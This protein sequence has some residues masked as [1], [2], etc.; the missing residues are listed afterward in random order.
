MTRVC[1]VLLLAALGLVPGGG[2]AGQPP[3]VL[4]IKVALVAADGSVRPIPRHA[5]LISE[6]PASS[7]PRR[8][9]T[10]G[11]G[12]A[13]VNLR[14]GTYTVES[15]QPARFEGKAFEWN[16]TVTIAAGRNLVLELNA[17]NAIEAAATPGEVDLSSLFT[18]V[19]DS[20]VTI[21]SETARGSG[22]LIDAKG[23]VATNQR[24]IGAATA[25]E[26]QLAPS[27]KVTAR[28]VAS[29]AAKNVA[30]LWIDPAVVASVRPVRMKYAQDG[31]ATVGQKVFTIG[32]QLLQP[33]YMTSGTVSQVGAHAIESDID[34]D[35]GSSGGPVFTAGGDVI[36]ITT[37]D[38]I[39]PIDDARELVAEAEAKIKKTQPP[40]GTLRPVEPARKLSEEALQRAVQG[41][42]G[43][44]NPYQ[45]P[46]ADFDVSFIT[47]V[48]TFG[49]Q[50]Q[51]ARVNEQAR[52]SRGRNEGAAPDA[53]QPLEEFTNWTDYVG[54]YLPVLMIRV[55]PK[56]VAGFW[57]SVAREA[58]KTQGVDL[59][60]AGKHAKAGFDR[61]RAFC[62]EAEV[63]PIHPFKIEH[64]MADS[65]D[66]ANAGSA[67]YEGLY[68]FDPGALGPE[69]GTV[70]LVLFSEKA[71]EKGDS[72]VVDAKVL[73]QIWQDFAPYRAT[74]R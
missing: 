10:A 36:G 72:R 24:N 63:T 41:R 31:P 9:V 2:V 54:E 33:K 44:L 1:L 70:K 16:Q 35:R 68:I 57:S 51:A 59:G 29:S 64:R 19:Q 49:A 39:V 56:L 14:P 12:T 48:M 46:A 38:G 11:D 50:S 20:V 17:A 74:L 21:W 40:K 5:L 22:F 45:M 69:C 58:I 55:T 6:N 15:D 26:V 3:S 13:D 66:A 62:G 43:S 37:S 28:V 61:M 42:T 8:V 27:V 53:A 32:S 67:I 34:I 65:G 25:A 4:H 30:I 52:K 18:Q 7:A 71:P 73:Q 60:P 47:P 23:L